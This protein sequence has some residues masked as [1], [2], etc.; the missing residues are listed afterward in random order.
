MQKVIHCPCGVVVKG[1]T[2]DALVANAQEHAKTHGMEL[3]REEALAMAKPAT[4]P[5]STSA[6][7][8]G[9]SRSVAR[10]AEVLQRALVL[11]MHST[12]GDSTTG[13]PECLTCVSPWLSPIKGAARVR[14]A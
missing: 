4:A 8:F 10:R 14:P 2:E 6:M 7:D 12:K 1:E 9:N 11:R 5:R 3:T 13:S